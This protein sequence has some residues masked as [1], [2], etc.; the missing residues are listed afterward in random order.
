VTTVT[1]FHQRDLFHRIQKESTCFTCDSV[2]QNRCFLITS[3]TDETA[4]PVTAAILRLYKLKNARVFDDVLDGKNSPV[5]VV[6]AYYR[7]LLA[8]PP[9]R[10]VCSAGFLP[11]KHRQRYAS[12]TVPAGLPNHRLSLRSCLTGALLCAGPVQP[13]GSAQRAG[14][15]SI[16][17]EE[18]P[19]VQ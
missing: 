2:S 7:S 3:V 8:L 17:P 16:A 10:R 5:S 18:A 4:V 6:T 1:L 13:S 9:T 11:V 19:H 12:T 14:A 15:S